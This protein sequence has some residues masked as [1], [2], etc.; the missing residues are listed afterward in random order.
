M[1]ITDNIINEKKEELQNIH[2]ID[3]V[4]GISYIAVKTE[5]GVGLS[6]TFRN[7]IPNGCSVADTDLTGTDGLT[8]ANFALGYDPIKS[9]I[10]FAVIN[11][12]NKFPEKKESMTNIIDFQDKHV[13]M[14]GFFR[15]VAKQIK[16][17][18]RKLDIFELKLSEDTLPSYFAKKILPD[19][20]IV[21]ITGTSLII[22][23]T[24]E[25]LPYINKQAETIFMGPTTPVCE[26][27]L[28]YGHI[29]GSK[30]T[31]EKGIFK[32]VSQ[33]AG[34]KKI[35]PFVEKFFVKKKNI[36]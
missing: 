18:V 2:I 28:K 14:I 35:K 3:Y 36:I 8:A 24:E 26:T 25:F 27:L 33:G 23:T 34:M 4:I 7:L 12:L 1:F 32:A 15:P 10:G 9:A 17:L 16:P 29:A 20:D 21:I 30:V 22:H 5:A 11:S 19:V 31:D 13:A 6:Y